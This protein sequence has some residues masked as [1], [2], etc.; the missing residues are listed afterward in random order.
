LESSINQAALLSNATRVLSDGII[1]KTRGPEKE[2]QKGLDRYAPSQ[3]MTLSS[4][5]G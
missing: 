5:N 1:R 2:A 4:T 3:A